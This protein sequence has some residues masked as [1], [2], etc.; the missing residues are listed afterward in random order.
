MG[1]KCEVVSCKDFPKTSQSK[2]L[3]FKPCFRADVAL[4][5]PQILFLTSPQPNLKLHFRSL[6]PFR[7]FDTS[8]H[9]RLEVLRQDG[10]LN[11]AAPVLAV[12]DPGRTRSSF[13]LSPFFLS[14]LLYGKNTRAT[15]RDQASFA[16]CWTNVDALLYSFWF[17]SKGM[18]T[19]LASVLRIQFGSNTTGGLLNPS[20]WKCQPKKW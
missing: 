12:H 7:S 17:T 19:P 13:S 2:H 9:L 16:S 1:A 4:I 8:T 10:E 15:R 6:G 5:H 3:T 20:Q 14:S 18:T 11:A